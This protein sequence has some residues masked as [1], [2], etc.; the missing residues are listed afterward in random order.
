M[1]ANCHKHTRPD[2][3]AIHAQMPDPRHINRRNLIRQLGASWLT[4]LCVLPLRVFAQNPE[5]R[6]FGIDVS[7]VEILIGMMLSRISTRASYSSRPI[8]LVSM[9]R[10]LTQIIDLPVIGARCSGLG[11]HTG[12]TSGAI[13]MRELR[14]RY[15]GSGRSTHREP[16]TSCQLSTSRMSTTTVVAFPCRSGSIR[17]KEWFGSCQQGSMVTSR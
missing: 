17:S 3:S 9:K 5:S 12:H 4:G 10:P 2:C 11:Y 8:T 7:G 14:P 13:R 15:A 16:A 1:S 6:I